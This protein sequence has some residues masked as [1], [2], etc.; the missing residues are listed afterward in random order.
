MRRFQLQTVAAVLMESS[1]KLMGAISQRK[2][3]KKVEKPGH[4][5]EVI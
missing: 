3:L 2:V 1:G 5:K 4:S